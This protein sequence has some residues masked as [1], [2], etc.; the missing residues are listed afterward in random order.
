MSDGMGPYK[1]AFRL[2][3]FEAQDGLCYYCGRQ[4]SLNRKLNGQPARD[5]ATL[6]HL[7]RRQQGGQVNST[8]IVLAHYKCNRRE[9]AKWQAKNKGWSGDGSPAELEIP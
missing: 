1:K 5:F 3:L 4:M 9:N 8:N 7:I 2:K 6:E